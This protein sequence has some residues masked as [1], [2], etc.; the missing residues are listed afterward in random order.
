[1]KGIGFS[2]QIGFSRQ[3]SSEVCMKSRGFSSQI[4][5]EI[6]MKGIGF[7]GQITYVQKV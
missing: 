7:L 6:C 4:L 2:S 1:M 5:S 3:I